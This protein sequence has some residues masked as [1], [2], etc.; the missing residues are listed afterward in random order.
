MD[1]NLNPRMKN[2]G[3]CKSVFVDQWWPL[4]Q[5]MLSLVIVQFVVEVNVRLRAQS[6]SEDRYFLFL[7]EVVNISFQAVRIFHFR[8]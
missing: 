5:Y 8:P 2:K 6:F 4:L 7:D 3:G 1:V